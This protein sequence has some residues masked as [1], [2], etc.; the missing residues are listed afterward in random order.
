MIL[1]LNTAQSS[2]EL[3]LLRQGKDASLTLLK[4]LRWPADRKGVET[5]VPRLQELLSEAD[6]SKSELTAVLSIKGPGSFTSLR[7]GVAFANALAEGLRASQPVKTYELDTFELLALKA[8]THDPLLVLLPAGGLD[9]GV[10]FEGELKVGH[11]S[12]LLAKLPHN[13]ALKVASE[14]GETLSDELHS[15]AHE[16]GWHVL[17]SHEIQTLGEALQTQGL[18]SAQECEIV[19]PFY[20]RGPKITLSSDPWKQPRA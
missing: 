2:H 16:K 4:E 5:L 19:E 3:A 13:P 8:A 6:I 11:L 15:I 18:S 12:D 20:L 17:E 14:L 7:T 10:F 9:A 1:A